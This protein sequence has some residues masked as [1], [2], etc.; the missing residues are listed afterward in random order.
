[1]KTTRK[2]SSSQEPIKQ[3]DYDSQVRLLQKMGAEA[4]VEVVLV[5]LDQTSEKLSE[6]PKKGRK[7]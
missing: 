7:R 3:L 5:P 4:G 1:M 6:A 2:N